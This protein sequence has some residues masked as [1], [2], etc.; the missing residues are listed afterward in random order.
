M[1]VR[2]TSFSD[3]GRPLQ[4]EL[5]LILHST[6]CDQECEARQSWFVRLCKPRESES[7]RSISGWQHVGGKLPPNFLR[8]TRSLP[9]FVRLLVCHVWTHVGGCEFACVCVLVLQAPHLWEAWHRHTV[10]ALLSAVQRSSALCCHTGVD[11][12]IRDGESHVFSL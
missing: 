12:I 2:S 8:Q 5:C 3:S 1:P 9:G 10:G 6:L 4:S 11:A 7:K